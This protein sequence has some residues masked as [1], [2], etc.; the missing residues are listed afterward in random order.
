MTDFYQLDDDGQAHAMGELANAALAH[1]GLQGSTLGLIKYRENAVFKLTT[2]EGKRF[3]LRIHRHEY[4]TDAELRSEL[5]WMSALADAGILVPSLVP[6]TS[7]EPFI[8]LKAGGVPEP[9][10][11]DLFEWVDGDQLGAVEENTQDTQALINA[12]RTIGSLMARLHNQAVNWT[13]PNGFT[14][15]SWDVEGLVG[16]QPFWG[17]FWQLESLSSE[18]RALLLEARDAVYRDLAAYHTDPENA[19]RYSMI[20]ADCVAENVMVD[21]DSVRLIDF[22]D[23]GFGWHLFDIATA[24]YFEMDE[25][26]FS[27]A[28][29]ALIAGYQ[30]NRTL[31]QAQIDALP[32]FY[33]ARGFTYLGWVHTRSETQTAKELTPML[34]DKACR[35]ANE[36][37]QR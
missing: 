28:R 3:A 4:H 17:P 2:P 15:H 12:Y 19:D 35:R 30:E 14:R 31:P 13:L 23:A 20:H 36:Y 6:S 37:F 33:L 5:Q 32:L 1:W 11:I 22:D 34:V 21:G 25:D 26:H 7:G 10:Q 9:R 16:E 24:L 29:D 27:S 8:V 18:Q